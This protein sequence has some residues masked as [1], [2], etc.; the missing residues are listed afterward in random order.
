MLGTL[1]RRALVAAA[2][3]AF[4]PTLAIAQTTTFTSLAAWTAALAGGAQGL[5]TF[6]DLPGSARP[7][8][9]NRTAGGFSYRASV[10]NP[11]PGGSTDFFPAGTAA[12][13]WLSTDAA[14]ASIVF[15]NFSP[16][17]QALG[18][19]FFGSN[20]LG[21]FQAGNIAIS[22]VTSLGSGSVTLNNP[23]VASFWG[24]VTTGTLTSV[25]VSAVQPT[26]SNLWPTVN[27]LRLG[28]VV[29]EPSTYALMATGLAGLA[30]V[31]RRRKA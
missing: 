1:R 4:V 9:L 19:A 30:A 11:V 7:S 31:R 17:T 18:G 27:D 3:V 28:T 23:A 24:I 13:R 22:W 26:G 29:P 5:D 2:A 14:L 8:P 16:G 6:N 20:I 15:S 10:T 25:T 21:N 12:D